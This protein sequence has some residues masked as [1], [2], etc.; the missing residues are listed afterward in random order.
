[1]DNLHT[2]LALCHALLG[3]GI[4]SCGTCRPHR[5]DLP[6][7]LT[8]FKASLAK[9]QTKPSWPLCHV[10]LMWHDSKPVL[11]LSTH[12]QP[13]RITPLD[14]SPF[15]PATFRPTV[16]VD[17]NLNKGHVDQVDPVRSYHAV[18]R[19]GRRSWPALAWWLLDMCITNAH[20][21]CDIQH[22]KVT[23]VLDFREKLLTQIAALYLSPRTPVQPTVPA[24]AQS[25]FVGHFPQHGHKR[26]ACAWC[27]RGRQG[28]RRTLYKCA[29]CGVALRPAPCFGAC[30]RRHEID[31]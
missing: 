17:Y 31:D 29:V 6:P 21:L 10:C 19:R 27:S 4:R 9:G 20:R 30:H 11:F 28:V 7:N 26:R 8:T 15:R 24:T 12:L 3:V 18:Q 1:M 25:R 22:S 23:E 16:A 14:P 13:D 5:A 2:S